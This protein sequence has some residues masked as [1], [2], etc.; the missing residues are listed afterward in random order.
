MLMLSLGCHPKKTSIVEKFNC[1]SGQMERASNEYG[2]DEAIP[3]IKNLENQFMI[4][5]DSTQKAINFISW[6]E[7]FLREQAA[8]LDTSD[9]MSVDEQWSKLSLEE[10]LQQVTDEKNR[11]KR[12]ADSVHIAKN[13]GQQRVWL[14]NNTSDTILIQRQD[15]SYVCI[16]EAVTKNGEWMPIQYWRLSDCGDSY[17]DKYFMPKT[18]NSFLMQWPQPGSYETK[19]RF[20]LLGATRFYYSNEFAGRINYCEFI[21][22]K[23]KAQEAEGHYKLDTLMHLS[24]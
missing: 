12:E 4:V 2:I 9:F 20:K 14:I 17:M 16:L 6:E 18:A 7:N 24:S 5:V 23:P 15:W 3:Q 19:L 13:Q 11:F 10:K 8:T 1:L 21:E 22:A